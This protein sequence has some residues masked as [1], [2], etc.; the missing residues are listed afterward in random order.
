MAAQI[1]VVLS[2][3]LFCG[4]LSLFILPQFFFRIFYFIPQAIHFIAQKKIAPKSIVVPFREMVVWTVMVVILYV[5]AFIIKPAIGWMLVDS[6]MAIACWV[7][8]GLQIVF[9][10]TT[11]RRKEWQSRFYK[12][13][14][15]KYASEQELERY[16]AFIDHVEK[17]TPTEGAMN[18]IGIIFTKNCPVSFT[19]PIGMIPVLSATNINISPYTLAGM[20]SGRR[21][22]TSSATNVTIS[23]IQSWYIYFI[24]ILPPEQRCTLPY[25]ATIVHQAARHGNQ[26]PPFSN[27]GLDC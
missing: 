13:I 22:F 24:S 10:I 11:K 26:K 25:P 23:I 1:M 20:G 12:N 7:L 6:P 4:F 9:I 5:A 17:I 2:E 21:Y 18:M 27:D 19:W 8:G 15:L 16:Y 14:Y 3:F